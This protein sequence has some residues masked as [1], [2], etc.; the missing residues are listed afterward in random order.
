MNG[1]QAFPLER[2][3]RRKLKFNILPSAELTKGKDAQF[4]FLVSL[5]GPLLGEVLFESIS[6]TVITAGAGWSVALES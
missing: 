3:Q 2:K 5:L 6:E 4:D 1:F